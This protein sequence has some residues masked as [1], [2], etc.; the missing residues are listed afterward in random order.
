MSMTYVMAWVFDFVTEEATFFQFVGFAR[1]VREYQDL[2][3][4]FDTLFPRLGECQNVAK[5]DI[6][7]LSYNTGESDV[8]SAL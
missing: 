1:T 2:L 5:R 7:N 3:K 4:M 6:G 8:H